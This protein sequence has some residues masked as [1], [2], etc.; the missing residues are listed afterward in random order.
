MTGG[1][2]SQGS[3]M[4]KAF[5]CQDVF[6]DLLP[7]TQNCGLR[8]RQECRERFPYHRG[9]TIPKCI[10][11]RARR[12]CR[13]AWSLTSGFLW[14]R[15]AGKTFPAFP[16]HAQPAIFVSGKRPMDWLVWP[17]AWFM[18]WGTHQIT[19]G[20]NTQYRRFKST[21]TR[22]FQHLVQITYKN[23]PKSRFTGPLWAEFSPHAV[24]LSLYS[25][26]GIIIISINWKFRVNLWV[27]NEFQTKESGIE[28]TLW[29]C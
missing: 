18:H 21:T 17:A 14:S 2:P 1:F 4:C 25:S 9:L 5:P 22:L 20:Q 29:M 16:A 26:Y 8:M 28:L 12:T 15:F 3:V 27:A 23:T 19:E 10:T 24:T 13:D 11:A 6:M 7:D